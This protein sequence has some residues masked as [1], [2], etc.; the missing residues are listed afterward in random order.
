METSMPTP[1]AKLTYDDFALFPEDGKRHELIDGEHHVTPSPNLR[2]QVISRNIFQALAAIAHQQQ[3]GQVFYAPLDVVLTPYDVVEP[4]LMYV[5]AGRS[6]I[7]TRAN[8]QGA[9]DLVAEILSPSTRRQDELLKRDLYE[10]GGVSEY[11]IV[12]PDAETVKVL[13][14]GDGPSFR[15][16][17]LLTRRDGDALTTPLLP[18]LELPLASVFAD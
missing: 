4:D 9:P 6:E 5:S 13:R 18:G 10:R 3:L 2:H 14:R 15:R 16:P 1:A 12:D 8:V 11:W 7:L 17:L